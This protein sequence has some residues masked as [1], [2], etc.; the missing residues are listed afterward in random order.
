VA[1]TNGDAVTVVD[2]ATERVI[3]NLHLPGRPQGIAADGALHR[4]FVGLFQTGRVDV[5]DETSNRLIGSLRVGAKPVHPFRLDAAVHRLYVVNSGS[6]TLSVINTRTLTVIETLRTGAHPEGLDLSP[7]GSRAYISNEGDP[8]T[9]R[10]SGHTASVIDL[11]SGRIVDT[12]PT[13][14]GP[15]GIAYD[16]N[17][18]D[19]YISNEDPSRVLVLHLPPGDR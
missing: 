7:D 9:D 1:A 10:N 11:R 6:S 17:N 2:T 18:G 3:R 14:Q 19:V 5:L 12:V 13:L 8:G 4:V 15:D 16:P